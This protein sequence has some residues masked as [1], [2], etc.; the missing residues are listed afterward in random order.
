M[1]RKLT[2]PVTIRATG[3]SVIAGLVASPQWPDTT[4]V[5]WFE[6]SFGS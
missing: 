2:L 1:S 6:G 3:V 4:I 5:H